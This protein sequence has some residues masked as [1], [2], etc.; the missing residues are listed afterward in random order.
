MNIQKHFI[1]FLVG[2][3]GWLF[4]FLLG[5]PSNYFTEWNLAEK[6]ILSLITFF[7]VVPFLGCLVII[8]LK[9]NYFQTGFWMAFYASVPVFILDFIAVGVIQDQGLLFLKSHWYI[10]IAYFYVWIEL[11]LIG[12]AL[13]KLTNEQCNQ[14]QSA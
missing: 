3:I 8:F 5:Y 1:L 14:R 4:F 11:P 12:L 13:Q 7:A 6:I 10:T 2:F 9:G